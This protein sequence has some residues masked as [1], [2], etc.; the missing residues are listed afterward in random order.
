V[1]AESDPIPNYPIVMQG[2]LAP[3]LKAAIRTAFLELKDNEIL[4][5]FRAKHSRRPTITPTTSC[6]RLRKSSISTLRSSGMSRATPTDYD[7]I[8]VRE[9]APGSSVVLPFS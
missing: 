6:G 9:D 4:K 1:L 7:A 2:Y 8:L 3:E 5:T